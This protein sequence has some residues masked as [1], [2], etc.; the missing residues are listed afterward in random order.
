MEEPITTSALGQGSLSNDRQSSDLTR[1][2]FHHGNLLIS[3][4]GLRACLRENGDLTW[5]FLWPSDCFS[6]LSAC[7]SPGFLEGPL[8]VACY[9]PSPDD[10]LTAAARAKRSRPL[11][12]TTLLDPC[13]MLR[14]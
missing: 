2:G 6:R 14:W 4:A 7:V 12:S 8:I 10:C 3:L 5:P 9:P 11:R 1:G 13:P